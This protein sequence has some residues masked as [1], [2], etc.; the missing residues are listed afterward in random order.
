MSATPENAEA[1]PKD[2]LVTPYTTWWMSWGVHNAEDFG[3]NS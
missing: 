1:A 2:G 3:V